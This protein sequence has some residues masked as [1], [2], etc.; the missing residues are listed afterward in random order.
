M[1]DFRPADVRAVLFDVDGTLADSDDLWVEKITRALGPLKRIWPRF[2]PKPAARRL[3]MAIEGPM[4]LIYMWWD[5]LFL[6]EL[7][8]P[9]VRLLPRS[10]PV[11]A[12]KP[13]R[14]IPGVREMLE[15]LRPRYKLAV[16]TARGERSTQ[17]F[18]LSAG[19][20]DVF[21]AMVT[22]RSARR[23]KPHPA[24]VLLAAAEL[25]LDPEHCLMVGDTTLDIRA[26]LAAGA[27][28]AAVLCG[29]GTPDELGAAAPH[30]LLPTTADL[31]AHLLPESA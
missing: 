18:L 7:T 2:Q 4:N 15:G 25:E 17:R 27:Q 3:L 14:L 28:T 31:L 24:P 12:S 21:D 10:Q 16:V 1:K 23:A 19:L 11:A 29:F 30:L 6:D 26:G 20:D 13:A 22:T 9:L 8:G 5:R